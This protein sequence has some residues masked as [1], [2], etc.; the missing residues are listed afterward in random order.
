ML[1]EPEFFKSE[2]VYIDDETEKWRIKDDAPQEMKDEFN[3][4]FAA[5]NPQPDDDG[6]VT[7]Y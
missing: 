4:F 1:Q 5:V 7:V 6:V 3:A 2:Y